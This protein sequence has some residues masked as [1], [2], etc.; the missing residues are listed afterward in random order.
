[1]SAAPLPRN[2]YR[3]KHTPSKRAHKRCAKCGKVV[4]IR[5]LV[6]RRCGKRQR[7][8]PKVLYLGLAGMFLAGM[9]A[10]AALVPVGKPVDA[11]PMARAPG[12]PPGNVG[13]AKGGQAPLHL[14]AADL[15]TAYGKDPAG[16]DRLYRGKPLVVTGRVLMTPAR[17]FRGNVVMRLGT[18]DA[19]EMV[20]AT[21]LGRDTLIDLLPGKGQMATVACTG[22]GTVIGAP[23]LSGCTLQ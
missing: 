7:V 16:A 19:L 21:M 15:W 14:S 17:D 13:G 5:A 22:S 1:M 8:N 2:A 10:V 9:F 6:C 3:M 4:A 18:G 11:A 23:L 20:H 12:G